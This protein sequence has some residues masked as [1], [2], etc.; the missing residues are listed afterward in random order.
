MED[1]FIKTYSVL[2]DLVKQGKIRHYGVSVEKIE[3]AK[4]AIEF[5]DVQSVQMIFNIFR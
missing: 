3:E 2:D 5:S 4:K 1:F